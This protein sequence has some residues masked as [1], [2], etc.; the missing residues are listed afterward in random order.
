MAESKDYYQI[1]AVKRE[2]T[3]RQIK[4]AFRKKAMRYHPDHNPGKEAWANKKLCSIIESYETLSDPA[5]RKIYARKLALAEAPPAYTEPMS[6][7]PVSAKKVMVDIMRHGA[8]P[9]WARTA[10]FA[11]VF[12]D[13]LSKES[14]R[15][16]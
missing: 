13:Y 16:E 14:R 12:F 10:A 15:A 6:R 1:L 11:Y 3:P 7:H 2:A 8:V 5:R 9:I 4:A